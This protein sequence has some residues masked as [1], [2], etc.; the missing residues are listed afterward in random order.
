MNGLDLK[1]VHRQQQFSARYFPRVPVNFRTL[2][3]TPL[4]VPSRRNSTVQSSFA[5]FF[6]FRLF[7][8]LKKGLFITSGLSMHATR[9]CRRAP[10]LAAACRPTPQSRTP[11]KLTSRPP[12]SSNTSSSRNE[13]AVRHSTVVPFWVSHVQ[14]AHA[15]G[16]RS[17]SISTIPTTCQVQV[18]N[19]R[20][21]YLPFVSDTIQI[22]IVN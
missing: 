8:D 12:V 2:S 11:F 21:I 5:T 19:G 10:P 3:E 7:V 20:F 22:L 14:R 16:P 9:A 1:K 17:Q 4:P 13:M 6:A 15:S 18:H